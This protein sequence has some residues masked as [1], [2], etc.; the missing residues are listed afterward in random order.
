MRYLKTAAIATAIAGGAMLLASQAVAQPITV[1]GINF[2]SGAVFD[3][4]ELYENVV[5]SPGDELS[6]YGR[7]N[8]INSNLHYCAGGANCELTFT[9][10]NYMVDT[11]DDNHATFS[12]G[13]VLFYA[14][15]SANFN[16]SDR[17]TA[18]DG[19]LF[20]STTGHKYVDVDSG[21]T[22]T[23]IAT[24]SNLTTD[25]AQ[26]NGVGYLDVTGGDAAQYFDTDTFDDFMGGTADLQFNSTITPN[27]CS[28]TTDEALCGTGVVKGNVTAVPEPS[29]LGLMGL[30]LLGLGFG[31]RRRR[32]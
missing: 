27:S 17:A 12:G 9:F 8:S 7:I 26:V 15:S 20:L 28:N 30:G 4:T 25:Q 5:A 24:G 6:G 3:A 31:V 1:D 22:G 14:D 18:S 32:K 10:S 13:Q 19:D 23:L 11:I 2:E 21:N 16:A 29:T